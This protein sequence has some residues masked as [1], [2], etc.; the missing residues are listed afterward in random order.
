[1]ESIIPGAA[2]E[3]ELLQLEKTATDTTIVALPVPKWVWPIVAV[4]GSTFAAGWAIGGAYQYILNGLA[5]FGMILVSAHLARQHGVVPSPARQAR[6]V[7]LLQA[8]WLFE[9]LLLGVAMWILA[10]RV[11]RWVAVALTGPLFAAISYMHDERAEAATARLRASR[12]TN[13]T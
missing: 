9:T 12:T 13:A 10:V 8:R 11:N 6:A 4:I 7:I 5:V 2:P 3:D 1:M